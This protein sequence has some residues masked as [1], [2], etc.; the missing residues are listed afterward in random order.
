MNIEQAEQ[1]A[2]PKPPRR[3][4]FASADAAGTLRFFEV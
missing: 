4:V 3:K 1:D 2:A